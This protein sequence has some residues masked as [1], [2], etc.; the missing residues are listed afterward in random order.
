MRVDLI[1]VKL[2]GMVFA[3][4]YVYGVRVEMMSAIKNP[5]QGGAFVQKSRYGVLSVK[6]GC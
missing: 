1:G 6:V 3:C 2:I 5:S 4:A